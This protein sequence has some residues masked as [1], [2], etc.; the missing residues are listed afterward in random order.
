MT[1][2]E[3]L[4]IAAFVVSV[5]SLIY[6]A[7]QAIYTRRQAIVMEQQYTDEKQRR[8]LRM[9]L[10]EIIRDDEYFGTDDAQRGHPKYLVLKFV[11]DNPSDSPKF[12][13]DILIRFVLRDS[14]PLTYIWGLIWE[15]LNANT[16][17]SKEFDIYL[18]SIGAYGTILRRY[19]WYDSQRSDSITDKFPYTQS[20]AKKIN[21]RLLDTKTDN[22]V[23]L[24]HPVHINPRDTFL[25]EILV[26]TTDNWLRELLTNKKSI[27]YLILRFVF[28]EQTED[29]RVNINDSIYP[30]SYSGIDQAEID[31]F[32]RLKE[33][34]D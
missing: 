21:I 32:I 34:A 9:G 7:Q 14:K 20:F 26:S 5:F 13:K 2:S 16:R 18:D 33:N 4:S 19:N 17:H 29:V 1:W 28:A 12:L 15:K 8:Q 31:R 27:H 3:V 6:T 30:S 23:D 11:I 10:T 24:V 22:F 25:L